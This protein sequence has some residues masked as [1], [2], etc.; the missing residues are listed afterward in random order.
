MQPG[1]RMRRRKIAR[2]QRQ[3][4]EEPPSNS[5]F[6]DD[7]NIE[8]EEKV[9][10][11]FGYAQFDIALNLFVLVHITVGSQQE[12]QRK[13]RTQRASQRLDAVCI[14]AQQQLMQSES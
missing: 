3:G 5:L 6:D 12:I 2:Q 4:E 13:I 9:L 8:P 14:R 11:T 1:A 10:K 7:D